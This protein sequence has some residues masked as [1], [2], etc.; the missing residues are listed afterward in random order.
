MG[1]KSSP[2]KR[3]T[4]FAKE[5]AY[6]GHVIGGEQ[7]KTDSGKIMAVEE[8]PAPRNI[9]EVRGFSDSAPIIAAPKICGDSFAV[10][11]HEKTV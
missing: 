1:L 5:V 4:L 11:E 6:P 9:K 7:M 10:T 3:F 8:W 2:E